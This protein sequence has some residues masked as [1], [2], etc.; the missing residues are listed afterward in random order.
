MIR[1]GVALVT[2]AS[3]GIGKATAKAFAQ[4]GAK[5]MLADVS[6]ESGELL[7]TEIRG[8]GGT[9]FFVRC[10]VS[11]DREVK[12]LLDRT[13]EKFGTIDFAFNNAGIEGVPAPTEECTEEN[14][15]RTLAVNLKGVWLCMKHE[16]EIMKHRSKGVIIN[17]SSVAGL[18]GFA[19][20]PAYTASKHGVL[21]LTK[22]AALE[23]A[24]AGIR[25]NAV[26]PGV[27]DTPMIERFSGYDPNQRAQLTAGEPI[28]RLGRPEEIANAVL[29]LCADEASFVTGA[30]LPV[31][32]GWV[33]Q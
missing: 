10:D 23:Y 20:I 13:I 24:K 7:A 11:Q 19:G 17:N 8:M 22:A 27:I 3:S 2:G 18:V 4:A 9:A 5:V 15:D 16:L 6:V 32:G 21:G 28:G 29:W 33:A 14:W 31:D 25:I 30:A 12:N 26:C 1:G